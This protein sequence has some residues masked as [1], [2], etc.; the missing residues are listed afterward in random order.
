MVTRW[1][2]PA[3]VGM[4][5]SCRGPRVGDSLE[6]GGAGSG[7]V[8]GGGGAASGGGGHAAGG[9]AGTET[10]GGVPETGGGGATVECEGLA[11]E[12][13][14]LYPGPADVAGSSAICDG[15]GSTFDGTDVY[16]ACPMS[17]L[18]TSVLL[19]EMVVVRV[20]TATGGHRRLSAADE[21]LLGLLIERALVA[22]D[23]THAYWFSRLADDDEHLYLRRSPKGQ[24]Q[25]ESLV[26]MVAGDDGTAPAAIAVDDTHVYWSSAGHGLFRAPKTGADA[27]EL[28]RA[29]PTVGVAV[30]VADGQLFWSSLDDGHLTRRD[31]TTGDETV[32]SS[33]PTVGYVDMCDI[34]LGGADLFFAQCDPPYELHRIPWGAA[35]DQDQV[36]TSTVDDVRLANDYLGSVAVD[37]A[38]VYFLGAE[39]VH[40]APRTGGASVRLSH[41][42]TGAHVAAHLVGVDARRVYWVTTDGGVLATA[43]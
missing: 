24:T 41:N 37:D 26:A 40:R 19:A 18:A 42:S 28:V 27:A 33:G 2:G 21:F 32:V 36:V 15:R 22:V 10:T 9:D 29:Y 35:A 25:P 13:T 38:A 4:L 14:V 30:A 7:E 39:W 17:T 11:C 16:V 12:P 20:E 23:D 3:I 8:A 1:L 6:T 43:K 5:L 31:L 34:A